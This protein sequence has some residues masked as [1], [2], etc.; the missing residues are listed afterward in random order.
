MNRYRKLTEIG[1]TGTGTT[2]FSLPT[3]FRWRSRAGTLR[4]PHYVDA[5]PNC[6]RV[7]L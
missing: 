6:L 3:S 5:F 2:G 7:H 4:H 1:D